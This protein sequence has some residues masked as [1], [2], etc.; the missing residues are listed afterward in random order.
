MD[1]RRYKPKNYINLC[2]NDILINGHKTTHNC[3]RIAMKL[4]RFYE[5]FYVKNKKYIILNHISY[6]GCIFGHSVYIR[7]YKAGYCL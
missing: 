5:T 3:L 6:N 2:K 1:R 7:V 4:N